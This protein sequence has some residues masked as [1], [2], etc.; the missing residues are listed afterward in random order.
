M[1]RIA[2]IVLLL[3]F[4][5][6]NKTQVPKNILSPQKM[7]KILLDLMEADELI[8]R[9]AVDSV[10]SDSFSRSVVYTAVFTQHKTNKEVFKKSFAF[11]E[12]HPQLLK[13]V[14]DSMQSETKTSVERSKIRLKNK[15]P[16]PL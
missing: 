16:L 14:L 8:G 15:R 13:V 3:L 10:S 6:T 5:C 12:S 1:I 9:K 4:S 7:Q 11:Y 2:A